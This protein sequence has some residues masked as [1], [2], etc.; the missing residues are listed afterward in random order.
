TSRGGRGASR[1]CSPPCSTPFPRSTPRRRADESADRHDRPPVARVATVMD[2]LR[3]I[4]TDYLVVGAGAAAMSFVD[5]LIEHSDVDIVM[6]ERRHRPGGHW[7]D[8]YPF[9]RLH[10]PST[11]YGVNSTQLGQG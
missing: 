1:R 6:V 5:T 10:Q 3:S 9:V 4:E 2:A 7:L 8:A 11:F